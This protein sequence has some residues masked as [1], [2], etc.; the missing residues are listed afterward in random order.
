MQCFHFYQVQR[1]G[2]WIN[3]ARG[4]NSSYLEE[5][6]AGGR[7]LMAMCSLRKVTGIIICDVCI[8]LSAYHTSIKSLINAYQ[9]WSPGSS[10]STAKKKI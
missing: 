8:F 7:G 4:Q 9:A 1:Q 10:L 2:K 5:D 6:V 3:G